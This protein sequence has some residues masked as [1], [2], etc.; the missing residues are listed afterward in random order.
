MTTLSVEEYNDAFLAFLQNI[1]GPNY[2]RSRMLFDQIMQLTT[3]AFFSKNKDENFGIKLTT[4]LNTCLG[5][6]FFLETK[7]VVVDLK[8]SSIIL[9]MDETEF[10][11]SM[12]VINHLVIWG[13]AFRELEFRNLEFKK[14][15]EHF[16]LFH[17]NGAP[18]YVGVSEAIYSK[19]KDRDN[20]LYEIAISSVQKFVEYCIFK[21][22]HSNTPE[23]DLKP[24]LDFIPILL[25][26]IPIG[27]TSD[28][29]LVYLTT[30][31]ADAA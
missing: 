12:S 31:E 30:K 18:V 1:Q 23:K 2:D 6:P 25:Q 9:P 15:N 28:R 13:L 14:D 22:I 16:L 10:L 8:S 3:N 27:C 29:E 21:A 5:Y 24:F 20:E 17:F 11:Q 4:A 7:E 26:A 19:L